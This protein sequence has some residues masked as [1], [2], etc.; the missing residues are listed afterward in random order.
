M[1]IMSLTKPNSI[2]VFSEKQYLVCGVHEYLDLHIER[3]DSSVAY[4][5]CKE[6]T[7]N[8]DI[9]KQITLFRHKYSG[10]LEKILIEPETT[11][12]NKGITEYVLLHI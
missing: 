11:T 5:F 10:K 6:N 2:F 9:A 4:L 12:N 3:I 1:N 8:I 7:I